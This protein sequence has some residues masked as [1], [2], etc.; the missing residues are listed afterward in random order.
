MRKFVAAALLLSALLAAATP[1]ASQTRPRRVSQPEEETGYSESQPRSIGSRPRTAGVGA[2]GELPRSRR[3]S[4]AG[5]LLRVGMTAA[6]LGV[7]GRGGSCSPSRRNILL[8]G[9]NSG[10][11]AGTRRDDRRR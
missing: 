2:A 6:V 5:T 8:G 11:N 10:I 7:G 9:V 3:R 4:L 1:L